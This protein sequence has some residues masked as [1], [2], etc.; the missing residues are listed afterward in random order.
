MKQN[1][2]KSERRRKPLLTPAELKQLR[3]EEEAA[4]V[5]E[6]FRFPKRYKV[7]P[8]AQRRQFPPEAFEDRNT[9]V[10][11]SIYLD[12]DVLN[13]FKARAEGGAP[14]QTQ[15]NAELRRIME[16]EQAGAEDPAR[17]LRQAKGLIEAALRQMG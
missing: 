10:R 17:N 14:Y 12:L 2:A 9:K 15:I 11:I 13:F 5:P 4:G 1:V 3:G 16:Q 8:K 6:E 7:I